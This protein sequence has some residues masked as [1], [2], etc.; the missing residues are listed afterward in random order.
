MI[1]RFLFTK[2]SDNSS[3]LIYTKRY[4]LN[5]FLDKYKIYLFIIPY[6]KS[7]EFWIN[8]VV[9]GMISKTISDVSWKRCASYT[10]LYFKFI[11][12][13]K[14]E[15]GGLILESN[16]MLLVIFYLLNRNVYLNINT[17]II[18]KF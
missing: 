3:R 16:W 6:F 12:P 15:N 18:S 17:A 8:L 4:L 14:W 2:V 10:I 1:L 13:W 7:D 9:T 5:T 11:L